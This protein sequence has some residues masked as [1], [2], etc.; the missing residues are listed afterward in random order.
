MVKK[1]N[2]EEIFNMGFEEVCGKLNNEH[3]NSKELFN[4]REEI[5]DYHIRLVEAKDILNKKDRILKTAKA[6][7]RLAKII[8]DYNQ[9]IDEG[10][11]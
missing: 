7:A 11:D 10:Y 6:K 3:Y 1:L 8:D 4:L 9:L 2:R 5:F